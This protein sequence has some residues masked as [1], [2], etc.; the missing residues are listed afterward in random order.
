M[1]KYYNFQTT[2][3]CCYKAIMFKLATYLVDGKSQN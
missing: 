3:I 2:I 1:Y